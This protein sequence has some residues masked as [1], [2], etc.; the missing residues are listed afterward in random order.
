MKIAYYFTAACLAFSIYTTGVEGLKCKI[1]ISFVQKEVEC[2]G[3]WDTLKAKLGGMTGLGNVTSLDFGSMFTK[4]ASA[5]TGRKRR[6]AET[7]VAPT[8]IADTAT[9]TQDPTKKYYCLTHTYL[10]ATIRSCAP[11]SLLNIA[12]SMCVEKNGEKNCACTENLCNTGSG[13]MPGKVALALSTL[14]LIL[15]SLVI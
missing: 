7:T 8:T 4:A 12:N 15:V 9:T 13:L 11:E 10:G 14:G 6:Q 1:G 5:A 3:S 2:S